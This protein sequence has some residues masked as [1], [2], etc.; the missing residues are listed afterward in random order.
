MR[1]TTQKRAKSGLNERV[2]GTKPGLDAGP[3]GALTGEPGST[4]FRRSYRR[5]LATS[6]RPP[7]SPSASW[8]RCGLRGSGWRPGRHERRGIQRRVESL[9]GI[10]PSVRPRTGQC[11][12]GGRARHPLDLHQV[13]HRKDPLAAQQGLRSPRRA[14]QGRQVGGHRERPRPRARDDSLAQASRARWRPHRSRRSAPEKG[15]DISD[16]FRRGRRGDRKGSEISDAEP[17]KRV[18]VL[19]R[20]GSEISDAL[21]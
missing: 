16:P 3:E 1:S 20:K 19:G 5:S 12:P 7:R 15:S 2:G 13:V 9:R 18:R 6:P 8:R 14:R 10:G 17:R 11:Q 21:I 4:W